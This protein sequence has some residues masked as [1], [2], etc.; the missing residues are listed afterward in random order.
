LDAVTRSP[1]LLP[2]LN[3]ICQDVSPKHMTPEDWYRPTRDLHTFIWA[4]RGGRAPQD[5]PAPTPQHATPRRSA[6]THDRPMEK[7]T[8]KGC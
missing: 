1:A 3:F 2:W 7:A 5:F 6:S 8:R 4:P